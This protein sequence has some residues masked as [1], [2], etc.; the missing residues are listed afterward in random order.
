AYLKFSVTKGCFVSPSASLPSKGGAVPRS[1]NYGSYSSGK[2]Q[3]KDT[4]FIGES[5]FYLENVGGSW[6]QNKSHGAGNAID[7]GGG[8]IDFEQAEKPSCEEVM[9]HRIYQTLPALP[10]SSPEPTLDLTI[11][12]EERAKRREEAEAQ[13]QVEKW[14]DEF[15]YKIYAPFDSSLRY[16]KQK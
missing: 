11:S 10:T 12:E 1:C 2:G 5:S 8:F 3:D 13:R 7:R 4:F 14:A 9:N 15:L 6:I 16:T